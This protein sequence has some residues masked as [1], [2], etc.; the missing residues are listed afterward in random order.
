MWRII[1]ERERPQMTIWR[2]RV[3]CLISKATNT[4]TGCVIL[5]AFPLQQWLH[6]RASKSRYAYIV[7][8][9]PYGAH[10]GDKRNYNSIQR[11]TLSW[12]MSNS[13]SGRQT[14]RP[15]GAFRCITALMHCSARRRSA[16]WH[17][18]LLQLIQGIHL[19]RKSSPLLER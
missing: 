9:V 15:N 16:P 12:K 18:G 17:R 7:C 11:N 6:E 2:M 1:V 10:E 5:I 4:H 8:H 13:N 14:C 3:A 19:I